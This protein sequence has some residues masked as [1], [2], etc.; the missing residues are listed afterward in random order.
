M[1]GD[2]APHS[3]GILDYLTTGTPA[4]SSEARKIYVGASRAQRLLVIA[5]PKSQAAR[6]ASLLQATGVS[7]CMLLCSGV[8]GGAR[9]FNADFLLVLLLLSV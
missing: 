9:S 8:E 1:L 2:V 4:A 3:Q 6:L 7:S 5:A